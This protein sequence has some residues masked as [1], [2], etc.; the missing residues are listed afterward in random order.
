MTHFRKSLTFIVAILALLLIPT[1]VIAQG[2]GGKKKKKQRTERTVQAKRTSARPVTV[3]PSKRGSMQEGDTLDGRESSSEATQMRSEKE[4]PTVK[5]VEIKDEE[6]K[7]DLKMTQG[8]EQ[9]HGWVD[10]GLP[11]GVKWSTCNVGASTPTEY[12]DHFAWGE[13]RTKSYYDEDNCK[14]Y[15][16]ESIGEIAGNPEYDAARAN[17]GG[18]WRMPTEAE[19]RELN[20]L[21]QW[22]WTTEQG[23]NGYRI[24]G[25]NGN[26][27]FLVAAG[28]KGSSHIY[29]GLHGYYWSSTSAI[30][31]IAISYGF[32][33]ASWTH[34]VGSCFRT[35]DRS[36]RA[37]LE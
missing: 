32:D 13:I 9:G 25:P 2:S 37:V 8:I 27:I 6:M 24:V 21:C 28:Y 5:P 34:H 7:P 30:G 11:S 18:S 20:D 31:D 14:T 26:S 22:G 3:T 33:S 36:V 15:H 35:F 10:L 17:W 23:I 1:V 29:A 19:W 16:E 4:K 12:G